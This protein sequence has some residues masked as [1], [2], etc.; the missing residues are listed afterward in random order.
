MRRYMAIHVAGC[1][2][3]PQQ[4]LQKVIF[5]LPERRRIADIL[6]YLNEDLP[7][8]EIVRRKIDAINCWFDYAWKIELKDKFLSKTAWNNIRKARLSSK[9]YKN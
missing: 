4:P 9:R 1:I 2:H 6:G 3:W 5:S 8:D 7:E